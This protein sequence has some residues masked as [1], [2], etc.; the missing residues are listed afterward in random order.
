MLR[1]GKFTEAIERGDERRSSL[2][3]ENAGLYAD[4]VRDNPGASIDERTDY[5]QTLINDTG[6]GSRGLPTRAA[7]QKSVDTYKKAEATKA[8]AA[9]K[10]AK[11]EEQAAIR[12]Q[13]QDISMVLKNAALN[14]YN[15]EEIKATMDALDIDTSNMEGLT[16]RLNSMKFDNWADENKSAI[17]AYFENPTSAGYEALKVKGG[18]EFADEIEGRFGGQFKAVEARQKLELEGKLRDL[19]QTSTD[20]ITYDN[21]VQSLFDQY[22]PSVQDLVESAYDQSGRDFSKKQKTALSEKV[23]TARGKLEALSNETNTKEDYERKL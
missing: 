20:Q 14:G 2:R 15:L 13:Q 21:A 16:E 5:A 7:M 4:F 12:Q 23:A 19:A 8:A 1:L 18:S 3:K 10:T 6:V 9:A 22:P 11:R 17:A